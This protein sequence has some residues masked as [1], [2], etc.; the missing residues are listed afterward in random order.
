MPINNFTDA[1]RLAG[2][3]GS[4][5]ALAAGVR[6]QPRPPTSPAP[7][8]APPTGTAAFPGGLPSPANLSGAISR[9]TSGLSAL[10][11]ALGG[12]T[13]GA[14]DP[15]RELMLR[16]VDQLRS[17]GNFNFT[18]INDLLAGTRI[19]DQLRDSGNDRATVAERDF[20]SGNG[21]LPNP[22]RVFNS[23]NYIITLGILDRDQ[24]NNPL[25]YRQQ[26]FER[27]IAQ[28]TGGSLQKRHQIAAEGN[29]HAEY[30]IEN[31]NID[32][33]VSPNPNTGVSLGTTIEFEVIEPY[34][35]GKFTEALIGSAV[36][37]GFSNFTTAPFCLRVDFQGWDDNGSNVS[38]DITPYYIPINF[39]NIEFSVTNSGSRYQAK[40][41]AM[42]DTANA[43][44]FN[45]I[46]T[47]VN[48]NGARVDQVLENSAESVTNKLNSRSEEIEQTPGFIPGFDKYV[49][50]F[51][52]SEDGILQAIQN[53][54]EIPDQLTV[55]EE[56]GV[57]FGTFD[58][59]GNVIP[60]DP[61]NPQ[62]AGRVVE[63]RRANPTSSIY[64]TIKAYAMTQINEIGQSALN[65]DSDEGSDQ[66]TIDGAE[67]YDD[68]ILRSFR[69]NI[70]EAQIADRARSYSFSQGTRIT[71]IIETILLESVYA[72]ESIGEEGENEDFGTRNWFRIDTYTFID[73]NT[74]TESDIGRRPRVYVYAVLP[75]EMDQA[76]HAASG[77]S[78]PGTE[79]L[80]NEAIKEYNYIYTGKNE[81]VLDFN[82]DFNY[83]FLQAAYADYGNYSGAPDT[84]SNA[85]SGVEN[86]EYEIGYGEG[87]VD[88]GL[89]AAVAAT[90]QTTQR[91][92]PAV[93][94][95]Y[96]QTLR[97]LAGG[98]RNT[99]VAERIAELFHDRLINSNVDMLIAEM[100]IWG[101]PYFLPSYNG[102]YVPRTVSRMLNSDG[103]MRYLQNETMIVV[104]FLTPIDYRQDGAL[105]DFIELEERF[106]G[107]Y[108]VLTVRN[109]FSNGEFKQELQLI[110]RHGQ[111]DDPSGGAVL[112]TSSNGDRFD[113]YSSTSTSPA[114]RN[115]TGVSGV[116]T[117]LPQF[118]RVAGA[119]GAL[120]QAQSPQQI[121]Q[122]F[123]NLMPPQVL[124]F[125]SQFGQIRDQVA[126][127]RDQIAAAARTDTVARQRAGGV[128]A[129]QT[130]SALAPA[131]SLRPQARPINTPQQ[132]AAQPLPRPGQ[133]SSG[134]A[135]VR[136]RRSGPGGAAAG[137]FMV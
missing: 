23:Y 86:P 93:T 67:V 69:R 64:N 31:L 110:R 34:S 96:I 14:L 28:S 101:D 10:T 74:Q 43:N 35:M 52:T 20:T 66:P 89:A 134:P 30:F 126:P 92:T 136:D 37:M 6:P 88:P 116:P 50:V 103:R 65:V 119:V 53:G 128:F 68:A 16:T 55:P 130:P 12:T 117:V 24:V 129:D 90:R 15:N 120:G 44:M 62:G 77:T 32:A 125:Q 122:A 21:R 7:T 17:L 135:A 9:L 76:I 91:E 118:S 84:A 123:A 98:S 114:G 45:Q 22:L 106:S 105:M 97:Q 58:A 5:P 107:L 115:A 48:V 80:S 41:I 60:V 94:G 25:I 112:R 87:Q 63:G 19:P 108:R 109:I 26:G 46:K 104:N 47:E 121:F 33:V 70:Q 85:T 82:I 18:G 1:E 3:G 36:E 127:V 73:E 42:S 124:N 29:D 137:G 81:D 61:D 39:I 78:P 40:A 27:I 72:Q 100:T 111:T 57:R 79:N 131:S 8:T 95:D 49:I 54:V 11:G 102:N 71:E 83:A 59:A 13:G 4:N 51:P 133:Q 99:N 132:T 113:P 38:A 56:L 75:Y 2:L